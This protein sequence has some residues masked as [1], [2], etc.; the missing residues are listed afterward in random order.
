MGSVVMIGIPQP[1]RP[2]EKSLLESPE[3]MR[4]PELRSGGICRQENGRLRKLGAFICLLLIAALALAIRLYHIKQQSVWIDEFVSAVGF[5]GI[6]GLPA[7]LALFRFYSCDCP[8]LDFLLQN[9]WAS[10]VG[11]CPWKL[12]LLP[13]FFSM[14]CVPMTYRLGEAIW[15][16]KVGLL[17]ALFFA[18]SPF[19]AWFAQT[20]RPPALLSFLVLL[21]LYS[22]LRIATHGGWKWWLLNLTADLLLL[23][24]HPFT[25]FFLTAEFVFLLWVIGPRRVLLVWAP[26]AGAAALSVFL[27]LLPTLVYVPSGQDDTDYQIPTPTQIAVSLLGND[28]ILV[29]NEFPVSPPNLPFL[30]PGQSLLLKAV[31]PV[32]DTML[33]ACFGL[34]LALAIAPLFARRITAPGGPAC[35]TGLSPR[36]NVQ[37]TGVVLLLCAALLPGIQ[38]LVLTLLWR[39][40]FASRYTLCSSF[41]LYLLLAVALLRIRRPILFG[42]ALA[43]IVLLYTY[44]LAVFLPATTRTDWISAATKIKA[45]LRRNDLVLVT[46]I[47]PSGRE[48]FCVNAGDLPVPVEPAYAPQEICER[49]Q[50]WLADP[51]TA[52]ADRPRVWAVME[53][54]CWDEKTLSTGFDASLGPF[55]ISHAAWSWPG[56]M[57]MSL[58]LFERTAPDGPVTGHPSEFCLPINYEDVLKQ[59]G[60][61]MTTLDRASAL[62]ALRRVLYWPF[63]NSLSFSSTLS[64]M[65]T[66]KGN[67]EIG[68]AVARAVLDREPAFGFGHFAEATALAALGSQKEAH[69]AFQKAFALDRVGL[70]AFEPAIRAWF[71]QRDIGKTRNE[72]DKLKS[73]GYPTRALSAALSRYKETAP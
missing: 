15:N 6:K 42:T 13:I 69:N 68:L 36:G 31:H 53:G 66:E 61:R 32:A 55:G 8:P 54:I 14:L 71:D 44:Q 11:V 1:L 70:P 16:R 22:C 63:P 5:L 33:C 23:W 47:L 17:A 28:A 34:A 72:L 45:D 60:P 51:V 26:F 58:Y 59:L 46:G 64:L 20:I 73:I 2:F 49:V 18:L 65:L 3:S 25:L 57:G 30:T 4:E 7:Q 40:C 39:P 38:L 24:A 10:L 67:P 27:W 48:L 37:R 52:P 12:R 29:S 35:W 21:A 9:S 19:H 41:S 62:D 56:M 50:H 43:V